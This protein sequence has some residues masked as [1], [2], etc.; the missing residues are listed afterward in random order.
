M[1]GGVLCDVNA[2]LRLLEDRLE[3]V[4]HGQEVEVL[5][6]HLERGRVEEAGHDRAGRE[7]EERDG[8]RAGRLVRRQPWHREVFLVVVVVV[9]RVVVVRVVVSAADLRGGDR[10]SSRGSPRRTS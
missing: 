4:I 8:D 3:P 5:A 9:V 2:L 6:E 7:D 10:W 1:R